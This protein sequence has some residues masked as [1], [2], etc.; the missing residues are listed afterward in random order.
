MVEVVAEGSIEV[1]GGRLASGQII[2]PDGDQL[3][4]RVLAY[5]GGI[6]G[7]MHMPESED[8]YLDRVGHSRSLLE[9]WT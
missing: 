8:R 6:F 5:P 7:C 1:L 2:I 4:I 9:I 3:G